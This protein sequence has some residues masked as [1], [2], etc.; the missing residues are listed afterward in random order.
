MNAFDF[1]RT[2]HWSDLPTT[3][4]ATLA[5]CL[6]DL[7][8]V[9]LAGAKTDLSAVL[10]ETVS[11]TWLADRSISEKLCFSGAKVA[12]A[13]AALALGMTVD[14]IDA[15]DGHRLCKGHAG[16]ALFG[17]WAPFVERHK[18]DRAEALSALA[19]GYEIALRAGIALH[20]TASDYHTSGAWAA[21]GVAAMMGRLRGLSDSQMLHALSTAEYHDPGRP[22]MR[23]IDHP[24][25]LK[26][27][28]G[29][30]AMA[31]V[32]AV[33]L[34]QRGFTG[35]PAELLDTMDTAS[36]GERWTLREQYFKPYPV[37][38]WAQPAIM[39]AA[40]LRKRHNLRAEDIKAVEI[41]SFHEACRLAVRHPADTEQA[42]YSMPFPVAALL[43]R[44]RLGVEEVTED[45]LRDP[46]ILAM[47]NRITLRESEL[48]NADFP[49]HRFATVTLRLRSGQ[50]L[51]SDRLEPNGDPE[52]PLSSAEFADKWQ[53]LIGDEGGLPVLNWN[54]RK[55]GSKGD[56][57]R[58]L[59]PVFRPL[60]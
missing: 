24:T 16:A 49:D 17:A 2:C 7:C 58:A 53:N 54:L 55:L 45:G 3:T 48:D 60:P 42:Q 15:H 10:R 46:A 31:G 44:G 56:F 5:L 12:P 13:G 4:K 30:C 6:K 22:M 51:V 41:Q 52:R 50:E 34:A 36:L 38:R 35:A 47:A 27:G 18:T 40:Q 21:V 14:A 25:I 1:I 57:R 9:A 43:V 39:G 37:C 33:D 59:A 29:W 28:A 32:T 23:S 11:Q 20:Q 26:N 19:V 8:A